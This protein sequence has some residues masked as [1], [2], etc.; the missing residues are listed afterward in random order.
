VREKTNTPVPSDLAADVTSPGEGPGENARALPIRADHVDSYLIHLDQINSDVGVRAKLTFPRPIVAILFR[1]ESLR[2]SD[3]TFWPHQ[4][5]LSQRAER[6]F[7]DAGDRYTL[8]P[9]R[10]T[11]RLHC[12][13]NA[14]IDQMRV[15]TEPA[16]KTQARE[17]PSGAAKQ[18]YLRGWG[19]ADVFITPS[20]ENGSALVGANGGGTGAGADAASPPAGGIVSPPGRGLS[21][22]P[23]I[24]F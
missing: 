6:Q 8:K 4:G 20:Q 22:S 16:I 23:D 15:L 3:R 17:A 9:D 2:A 11:L 5:G 21:V 18:I 7:G 14:G 10:R 24:P 1:H 19:I 13:T 12:H